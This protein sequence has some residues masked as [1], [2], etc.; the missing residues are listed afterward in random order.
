MQNAAAMM[1]TFAFALALAVAPSVALAGPDAT[2]GKTEVK[3]ALTQAEQNK[4]VHDHHVN[5]ME[6]EMG[7]VAKTNSKS[8]DVKKYAAML[9]TDHTK[10]DKD[11]TALAKKKGM[12]TIPAEALATEAEKADHK[13]QM[14]QMAKL[15]TLKGAEFDTMYLQMMVEGH[16][17]EVAL[18]TS[19]AATVTDADVKAWVEKRG[20]SLKKHA[21]EARALQSK[22]PAAAATK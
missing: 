1:K 10:A 22:K 5:E 3:S 16:D 19:V 2:A 9:V 12:A 6:I 14:D 11:L 8:A 4:I 17:K 18:N 15:K 20:E 7:K 13:A 21:D